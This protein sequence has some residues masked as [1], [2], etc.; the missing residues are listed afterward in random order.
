MKKI[1]AIILAAVT[2]FALAACGTTNEPATSGSTQSTPESTAA[3]NETSNSNAASE[4]EQT[5]EPAAVTKILV[6]YFSRTGEQYSVGNI[7]KGNTAIVAE[8]IA[9]KTGADLYEILPETD[10]YPYTYKELTDVA[11]KEQ[12]DNA[13][14]KIKG[15]LPDVSKYD[16]VFI[17]APVWWGDWPMI[18]YTFFE[19]VDLSGKN[20][21]PFSTHE[22]SGL[23]GF[24]RK[25]AS[26]VPGATVLTGQAFRGGDCQ[27]KQ[28][29]VRADVNKW[30]DGLGY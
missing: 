13:R 6:V 26:A 1:I 14:P 28:S 19:S 11:K 2:L 22:G 15:E 18:C 25:L 8:M 7:D 30:I 3:K 16:T 27:N 29:D 23:S 4:T 21:V 9:E 17:G 24:E 10:Y 12:N 20:L 5:T